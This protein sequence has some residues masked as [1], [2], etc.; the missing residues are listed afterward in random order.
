MK[1]DSSLPLEEMSPLI[2]I[3][4]IDS[5]DSV[6]EYTDSGYMLM[7]ASD[8]RNYLIKSLAEDNEQLSLTTDEIKNNFH[9]I[10]R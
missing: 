4:A 3:R 2:A 5:R 7:H 1:Y 9:V 10:K 6:S 8:Y